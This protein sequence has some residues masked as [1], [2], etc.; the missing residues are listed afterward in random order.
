MFTGIIIKDMS[1]KDLYK[2]IYKKRS[3]SPKGTLMPK[4]DKK[5][6]LFI[7]D[8]LRTMH[9]VQDIQ[10]YVMKSS[11]ISLYTAYKWVEMARRIMKNID[12]GLS[13]QDSFD[14]DKEYRNLINRRRAAKKREKKLL[15]A[16]Q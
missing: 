4:W 8:Q 11:N 1:N 15:L 9:D 3:V 5:T 7:I 2:R 13:I 10:Y 12:N 6:I 14:R 16:N